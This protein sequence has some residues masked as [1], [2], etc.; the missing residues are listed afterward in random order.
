MLAREMVVA[1]VEQNTLRAGG[2]GNDTGAELLAVGAA[3]D[4]GAD[5]IGAVV[6]A[7]G[8]HG[9]GKNGAARGASGNIPAD[10]SQIHDMLFFADG[11]CHER[12]MRYSLPCVG[13][14]TL[15]AV[16]IA[17]AAD[18]PESNGEFKP[19]LANRAPAR[20]PVPAGMS[21][22]PGGEFSMGSSDPTTGI[23][24]GTEPMVDARPVHRVYV[25]GFWMDATEVTNEAFARFV[26][27]TRYVTVAERKP[28]AEDFPSAEA[29]NEALRFLARITK[30][31]KSELTHK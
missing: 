23:C 2:V 8:K 20:G 9:A 13:F 28:R 1:R 21:W 4:E 22:I 30:E 5:G 25:D 11:N 31:H 24:G 14:I 17:A 16:S 29:V 18:A 12:R 27:A 26:A 7:E 3:D 10:D 6:D 15:V 19:T